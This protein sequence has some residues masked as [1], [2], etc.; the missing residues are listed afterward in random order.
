MLFV[1]AFENIFF[2][3]ETEQNH[4]FVKHQFDILFRHAFHTFLEFVV[5]EQREILWRFQIQIQEVFKIGRDHLLEDWI[6]HER[7]DQECVVAVFQI[8]QTLKGFKISVS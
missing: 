5:N 7:L 4:C 3:E 8:K 1:V 6:V 2:L